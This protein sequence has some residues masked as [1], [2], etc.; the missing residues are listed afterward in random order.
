MGFASYA[1]NLGTFSLDTNSGCT[2]QTITIGENTYTNADTYVIQQSGYYKMSALIGFNV[3]VA[4][5]DVQV[6]VTLW[7]LNSDS[8]I[9]RYKRSYSTLTNFNGL[10]NE[11]NAFF[12]VPVELFDN[13]SAGDIFII[14]VDDATGTSTSVTQDTNAQDSYFEGFLVSGGGGGSSLIVTDGTTTVDGVAQITFA[15]ATVTDDG[16]G[17]VTVTP[18]GG[19]GGSTFTLTASGN[20]AAQSAVSVNSSGQAVQTWGPAPN[21]AGV[22]TIFPATLLPGN[23]QRTNCATAIFPQDATHFL[24]WLVSFGQSTNVSAL[25]ACSVSGETITVGTPVTS[26]NPLFYT[27]LGLS[28]SLFVTVDQLTGD[29]IAGSISGLVI[30]LGSAVSSGLSGGG[31]YGL[32]AL[33]ATSFVIAGS[34]SGMVAVGTISGTTITMGAAVTIGSGNMSDVSA[35]VLSPTLFVLAYNDGANSNAMTFV[36]GSVSTRTVTLGT[37]VALADTAVA[38]TY[39]AIE[40]LT[41]TSFV[42]AFS[43]AALVSDSNL[44]GSLDAVVGTVSTLTLT[45]GAPKI[46]APVFAGVTLNLSVGDAQPSIAVI[47]STHV[48]FGAGPA[49]PQVYTVSGTSLTAP[50]SLI[51]LP[52]AIQGH[53]AIGNNPSNSSGLYYE[54]LVINSVVAAGTSLVVVDGGANVFEVDQ[55]TSTVSPSIQHAGLT[56]YGLNP[57]TSTTVLAWFFDYG[58]NFQ[59]RVIGVEPINATPPIGVTALGATSGNPVTIQN[60]GA[61]TG[62]SGLTPGAAYYSNGDGSLVTA[63]TGHKVGTAISATA[64]AV[65]IQSP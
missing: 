16:D 48:A 20:I 21:I 26:S 33:S 51:Y 10:S 50:S 53:L 8:S 18:S 13:C 43:N 23:I 38:S 41:A 57:L 47:D 11:G 54:T 63:N 5:A 46:I 1:A 40:K 24:A 64:L 27:T 35:A 62:L 65:A 37:P 49:L 32:Q 52:A 39:L 12:S 4:N 60:S 17:D 31:F 58:G 34:S 29:V 15:D 56:N 59:A 61:L 25:C 45:L 7:H 14:T 6:L 44:F 36:A 2:V 42:A 19:G 22:Q 55:S 9:N 28:D 3:D 30:T